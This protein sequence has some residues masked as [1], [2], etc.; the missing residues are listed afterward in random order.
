MPP[1]RSPVPFKPYS[2][3]NIDC[4]DMMAAIR[5]NE[6][7]IVFAAPPFNQG[8]KHRSYKGKLPLEEYLQWTDK[9]FGEAM[10][11]APA[12]DSILYRRQ[13]LALIG[14]EPWEHQQV[15]FAQIK[16]HFKEASCG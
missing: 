8:E 12:S 2:V 15:L 4:L 9:W 10:L 16:A 3:L 1:S 7:D 14:E 5:D 6:I 11:K 13:L